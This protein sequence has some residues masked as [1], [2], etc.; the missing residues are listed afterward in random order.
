MHPEIVLTPD[1]AFTLF[2]IAQSAI[3]TMAGSLPIVEKKVKSTQAT[4]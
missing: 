1:E 4:A 2:E 3:I